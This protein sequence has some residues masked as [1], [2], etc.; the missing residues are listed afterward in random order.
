MK[1]EDQARL[2]IDAQ[3]EAAGWDVQDYRAMNIHA[4]SGVAVREFKLNTGFADYLL[5]VDGLAIGVVEAKPAGHTL[6]GVELQGKK[7]REGLPEGVPCYR[8]PLKLGYESTGKVTQFTNDL[9]PDARSREVFTFHRPEELVRLV[10]LNRQLRGNLRDLPPLERGR[11]WS[12]QY[13]AIQNLERTLAAN[14]PRALIQ[15][16]TGSGKTYTACSFCYRLIKFGKAKRILFLVDRNNLA[17]QTL[18]EFQQYVSPY[19]NDQFTNEYVVQ[20]LTKNTIDPASKVVVT[21]IQRLYSM[22]QGE[23]EFEEE[24]EEDSMF[25]AESPLV[26]QHCGSLALSLRGRSPL[27]SSPQRGSN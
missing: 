7:Y 16:A 26:S 13:D 8:R 6:S 11:L 17:K 23:E 12:V 9:E 24:R 27:G 15:M 1:P 18:N 25:E 21:T 5:Y 2:E 4:A 3:L 14:R 10:E 22:L 19:T 20:R